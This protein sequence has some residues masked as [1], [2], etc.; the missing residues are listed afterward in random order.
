MLTFDEQDD[1]DDEDYAKLMKLSSDQRRPVL[2]DILDFD[3]TTGDLYIDLADCYRALYFEYQACL[4][5]IRSMVDL[6]EAN[7]WSVWCQKNAKFWGKKRAGKHV[8]GLLIDV[9]ERLSQN[10]LGLYGDLEPVF[11]KFDFYRRKLQTFERISLQSLTKDKNLNFDTSF[12]TLASSWADPDPRMVVQASGGVIE[13]VCYYHRANFDAT[14][15]IMVELFHWTMPGNMAEN[16]LSLREYEEMYGAWYDEMVSQW[17]Q[18]RT[19]KE[20]ANVDS[21]I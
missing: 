7:L 20:I 19:V 6:L 4:Q 21:D 5:E 12:R 17:R 18:T 1:L 11:V 13:S 10:L 3:P 9:V 2:L 15:R 16:V 14:L 8:E